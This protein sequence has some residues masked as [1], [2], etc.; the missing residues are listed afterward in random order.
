MRLVGR[1]TPCAPSSLCLSLVW[2]TDHT[3][4]RLQAQTN[5]PSVGLTT[6]WA[7]V[8]DSTATNQL[9]LPLHPT[10]GSVFFRLIYP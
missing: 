5:T 1:V 7:D 6:N 10:A 8:P 9:T 2:P 3:G 4:W